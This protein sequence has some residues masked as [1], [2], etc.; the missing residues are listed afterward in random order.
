MW[1]NGSRFRNRI[2]ANGLAYRLYLPISFSIGITFAK[3][4]RWLRTTPLGSAVAPEVK[5]ISAVVS[6]VVSAFRAEFE[7]GSPVAPSEPAGHTG[8]EVSNAGTTSP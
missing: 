6:D 5:M 1:L 8:R 3:M 2:G 7:L 4:L